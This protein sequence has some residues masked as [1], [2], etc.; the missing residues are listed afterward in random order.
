MVRVGRRGGRCCGRRNGLRRATDAGSAAVSC[1][2][3]DLMPLVPRKVMFGATC[4]TD[5]DEL[6]GAAN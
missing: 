5:G 3:A 2:A 4:T 1:R 6:N